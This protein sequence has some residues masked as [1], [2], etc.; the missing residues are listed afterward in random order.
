MIAASP[1]P[2][3]GE[4]VAAGD[5]WGPLGTGSI[6]DHAQPNPTRNASHCDLP[7]RGEVEPHFRRQLVSCG[8]QAMPGVEQPSFVQATQPSLQ[9]L[10]SVFAWPQA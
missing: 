9:A 7:P 2:R 3:H 1:S 5:G 6:L 8:T 4:G 10:Q